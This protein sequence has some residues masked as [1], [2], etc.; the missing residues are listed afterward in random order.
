LKQLK[1]D[2]SRLESAAGAFNNPQTHTPIVHF[3]KD[4]YNYLQFEIQRYTVYSSILE[5]KLQNTEN[6]QNQQSPKP[7]VINE[8][9][10]SSIYVNGGGVSFPESNSIKQS[11]LNGCSTVSP[12]NTLSNTN[13]KKIN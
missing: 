10:P 2:L 12:S 7:V 13:S 4:K 1:S 5:E 6:I 3:D 8:L 11:I 9:N